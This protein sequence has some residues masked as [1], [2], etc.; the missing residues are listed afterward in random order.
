MIFTFV[1]GTSI[2]PVT[3]PHVR[4]ENHAVRQVSNLEIFQ[5]QD[6]SALPER[7]LSC[8]CVLLSQAI[9]FAEWHQS[10]ESQIAACRKE[11]DFSNLGWFS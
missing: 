8:G 4:R 7:A 2:V 9:D 6:A 11:I 3:S 5:R 10:A 1:L